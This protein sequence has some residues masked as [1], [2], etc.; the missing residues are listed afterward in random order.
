M[1]YKIE[2]NKRNMIPVM[3]RN[4]KKYLFF[5]DWSW[6]NLLNGTK[7]F[8]GQ[9]DMEAVIA[10]LEEE[11]AIACAAYDK[12]VTERDRL[13]GEI[14]QM[15]QDKKDM[16]HQIEQEQGDLSSYQKDLATATTAKAE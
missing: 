10:K 14:T 12:E 4:F 11:A 16:L 8:I 13:N 3:Q 1:Q 2:I 7:R 6:Y 5:R 15:T 9:E